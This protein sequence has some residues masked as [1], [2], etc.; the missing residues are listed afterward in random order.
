MPRM[1]PFKIKF[2]L[3]TFLSYLNLNWHCMAIFTNG[4]FNSFFSKKTDILGAYKIRGFMVL[5]DIIFGLWLA[6]QHLPE[7]TGTG[8]LATWQT[9]FSDSTRSLLLVLSWQSILCHHSMSQKS[10]LSFIEDILKEMPHLR[11]PAVN[12]IDIHST[13]HAGPIDNIVI[14]IDPSPQKRKRSRSVGL[15]WGMFTGH[16]KPKKAKCATSKHCNTRVRYQE[17]SETAKFH[18]NKY[19][20]SRTLRKGLEDN[21]LP[22][23]YIR[24]SKMRHCQ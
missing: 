20:K 17:K 24:N 18:M 15:V 13:S 16:P 22:K 11:E 9:E 10:S 5:F 3:K 4:F 12:N 1:V 6:G 2:C 8:L 14:V 19:S 7:A 21:R 23:G